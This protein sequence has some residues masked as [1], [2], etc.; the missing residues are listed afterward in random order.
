[1][2][3]VEDKDNKEKMI[4]KDEANKDKDGGP[5]VTLQKLEVFNHHRT[6]LQKLKIYK[7]YN[8]NIISILFRC[9]FNILISF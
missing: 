9:C 4:M 6:T 3:N 7:Q 8:F 2:K 1:V 5:S